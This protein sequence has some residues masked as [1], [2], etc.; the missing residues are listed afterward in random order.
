MITNLELVNVKGVSR[1]IPCG[2]VNVVT[3]P[4]GTGKSAV[5]HAVRLALR[6]ADADVGELPGATMTLA[7][8]RHMEVGSKHR[9]RSETAERKQLLT[10]DLAGDKVVHNRPV[11]FVSAPDFMLSM[12]RY[13]KMTVAER[14]AEIFRRCGA[15]LSDFQLA[16]IPEVITGLEQTP[17]QGK[18][19]THAAQFIRDLLPELKRLSIP[20]AISKLVERLKAEAKAAKDVATA[21][22]G[23][24]RTGAASDEVAPKTVTDTE[25]EAAERKVAELETA[26]TRLAKLME[27]PDQ[28]EVTEALAEIEGELD[29]AKSLMDSLREDLAMAEANLKTCRSEFRTAAIRTVVAVTESRIRSLQSQ[30]DDAALQY[31]AK[32]GEMEKMLK[33]D[34]C[35]VCK[36]VGEA[37]KASYRQHMTGE[38]GA[39]ITRRDAAEGGLSESRAELA[40]AQANLKIEV[41]AEA[42]HKK[43]TTAQNEAKSEVDSQAKQVNAL[44]LKLEKQRAVQPVT[45]PTA[46]ELATAARDSLNAKTERQMLRDSKRV[47]D[48][49]TAGLIATQKA[50]AN[51]TE[52]EGIAVGLKMAVE[53]VIDLQAQL[54]NKTVG[55]ICQ[56]AREFTDGLLTVT[57][58]ENESPVE[59][60]YRD[61][62]FGYAH[63][64]GQFVT[65]TMS[66]AQQRIIFAG[67]HYALATEAPEKIM[68]MDKME[69]I[70]PTVLDTMLMRVRELIA[71]GKLDQFFGADIRQHFTVGDVVD[72]IID[73]DP[74]ATAS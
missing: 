4:N 60:D 28:A 31:H 15:D 34:S 63:P 74:T 6:G 40:Q 72:N 19:L 29:Q 38:I 20:D 68:V 14:A 21:L 26:H 59:I 1:S 39:I 61:G 44:A 7:S 22:K 51:L 66:D 50:A 30:H 41:E 18:G 73:M 42:V 9:N 2:L 8:G 10:W 36:C 48:A 23:T 65:K 12:R 11:G 58:K 24:I 52:K 27:L 46:E 70:W 25:I 47:A 55:S 57:W 43:A 53:A 33:G 49:Y 5:L 16:K 69:S 32:T 62:E 56:K 17:E 64:S 13:E 45:R 71:A 35:P 67:I 3:G 37:W 54:T